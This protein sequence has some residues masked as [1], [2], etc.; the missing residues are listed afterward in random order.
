MANAAAIFFLDA[1]S[2]NIEK[3]CNH[4]RLIV[5]CMQSG[6][7]QDRSVIVGWSTAPRDQL[8]EENLWQLLEETGS[9]PAHASKDRIITPIGDETGS[10]TPRSLGE[11]GIIW[12]HLKPVCL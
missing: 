9:R 5:A 2:R 4:Y 12:V 7:S 10:T 6:A 3:R 1:V 8:I 11:V